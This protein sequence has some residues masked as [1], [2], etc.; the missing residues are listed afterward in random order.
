MTLEQE[1]QAAF[2]K[3]TTGIRE[4]ENLL[5]EN[6]E[7]P[8]KDFNCL[9]YTKI[10]IP[11]NYIRSKSHFLNSY[12]LRDLIDE[13]TYADS[14]AF[15]LM[16]SDF[17][18][19]VINRIHL[20]GITQKLFFKFA[21]INNSSVIEAL[22]LCSLK[23]TRKFCS[24]SNIVCKHNSRCTYYISST[25]HMGVKK[26]IDIFFEQIA[27]KHNTLKQDFIDIMDIRDKVHLSLVIESEFKTTLYSV[28]NYNKSVKIL[29]FLRDNQLNLFQDFKKS[30]FK[31][32]INL[33]F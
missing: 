31:G 3:A 9:P 11:S 5:R 28:D 23:S 14:I 6:F 18:N 2:N 26:A 10:Q 13:V 12:N 7:N 27:F 4:L 29:R 24:P 8:I 30:R 21:I 22:L 1:I 33:P 15:S 32:C 16:Q 20:W 25:K 19:Y 17:N